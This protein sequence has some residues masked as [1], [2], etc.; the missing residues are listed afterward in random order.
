LFQIIFLTSIAQ[1]R[2]ASDA[3]SRTEWHERAISIYRSEY[4]QNL[5]YE[6]VFP[7]RRRL[8]Q[9]YLTTLV[10]LAAYHLTTSS[11]QQAIPLIE[12]AI[13]LDWLNEDLY[14][15][16]MRIYAKAGDR[17]KLTRVYLEMEQH[18]QDELNTKPLVKTTNLYRELQK[19]SS[20]P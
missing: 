8:T 3:A 11:P 1:A 7:E 14:C 9:A 20:Q 15:L 13:P 6:W 5:Y 10:E 17:T 18:L 16:A 2:V 19:S 4:L 12:T